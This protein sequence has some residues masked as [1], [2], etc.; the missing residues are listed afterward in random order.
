MVPQPVARI[1][2]R[3]V[4]PVVQPRSQSHGPAASSTIYTPTPQHGCYKYTVTDCVRTVF[5]PRPQSDMP[6]LPAFEEVLLYSIIHAP[7]SSLMTW[8]YR[9]KRK[10]MK[11][12]LKQKGNG[13]SQSV[14]RVVARRCSR[15]SHQKSN[16]TQTGNF[17]IDF[18]RESKD[19][20]VRSSETCLV[21][22]CVST[23]SCELLRRIQF[24]YPGPDIETAPR[25]RKGVRVLR[26][27]SD[28]QSFLAVRVEMLQRLLAAA[29][30]VRTC[31]HDDVRDFATRS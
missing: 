21:R 1:S 4:F 12:K 17:T 31:R 28:T 30:G 24:Q 8:V 27:T 15:N 14:L 11:R 18:S 23:S 22:R 10:K 13:E 29:D 26:E 19:A 16:T 5:G 20:R 6:P 3:L 7:C 25:L 9:C 2:R